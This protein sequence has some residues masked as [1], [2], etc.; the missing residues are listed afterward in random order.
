VN[1]GVLRQPDL[2]EG[3]GKAAA[4]RWVCATCGR[5]FCA[6]VTYITKT[7]ISENRDAQISPSESALMTSYV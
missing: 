2:T 1:L 4:E 6:K 3:V 5:G 7:V